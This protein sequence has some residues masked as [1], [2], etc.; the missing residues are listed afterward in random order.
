MKPSNIFL[1]PWFFV[2]DVEENWLTPRHCWKS[3]CR[4]WAHIPFILGD[5]IS[6]VVADIQSAVVAPLFGVSNP[7]LCF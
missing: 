5:V 7:H 4:L 2:G 6:V 3:H 1:C